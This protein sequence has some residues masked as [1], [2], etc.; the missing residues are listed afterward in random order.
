MRCPVTTSVQS[1]TPNRCGRAQSWSVARPKPGD[2]VS[3]LSKM[4]YADNL[5]IKTKKKRNKMCGGVIKI[6]K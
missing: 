6:K 3:A 4:V 5:K 1:T 2:P